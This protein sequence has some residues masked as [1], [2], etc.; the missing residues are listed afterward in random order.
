M[1]IKF[2]RSESG[3]T[4]VEYALL[5]GMIAAVIVAAVGNLGTSVNGIYNS[6]A[7]QL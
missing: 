5:I 4:A 6:M 7:N 2:I 3:A 1:K